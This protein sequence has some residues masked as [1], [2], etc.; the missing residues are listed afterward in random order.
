MKIDIPPDE[1]MAMILLL[2]ITE[3]PN[4]ASLSIPIPKPK[5]DDAAVDLLRNL[6]NDVFN[7]DD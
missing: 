4:T 7:E 6:L 3:I 5:S 1:A 2:R